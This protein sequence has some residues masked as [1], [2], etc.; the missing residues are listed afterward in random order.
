MLNC[1]LCPSLDVQI[2][3]ERENFLAKQALD[4]LAVGGIKKPQGED[5]NAPGGDDDDDD[6]NDF[7]KPPLP[8]AGSKA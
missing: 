4:S 5:P 2:A 1:Y 6:D 8:T 3:I 7:G